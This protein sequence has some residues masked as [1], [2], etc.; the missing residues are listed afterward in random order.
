MT[1]NVQPWEIKHPWET[2][3]LAKYREYSGSYGVYEIADESRNVL[4]VG[5]AGGN[6][7]YGLRGKIAEHFSPDEPNPVLR[8]RARYFRYEVSNMYVSRYLEILGRYR[9]E[10]G[11][12]PEGNTAS[13]EPLPALPRFRPSRTARGS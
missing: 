9:E 1:T 12:L 11:R 8:E 13:N 2:Y 4:Y 5:Q 3:D 6:S 10:H 7:T